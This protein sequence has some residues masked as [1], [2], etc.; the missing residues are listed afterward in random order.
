LKR[1]IV[2]PVPKV[3]P[4]KEYWRRPTTNIFNISDRQSYGGLYFGQI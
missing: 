2:I 3:L 4:P 1:S